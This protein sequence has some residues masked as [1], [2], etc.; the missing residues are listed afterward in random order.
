MFNNQKGVSYVLE[1]TTFDVSDLVVAEI[2]Y[3]DGGRV[4][5]HLDGI[6]VVI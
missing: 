1:I 6:K 5:A 3:M 4:A 2:D